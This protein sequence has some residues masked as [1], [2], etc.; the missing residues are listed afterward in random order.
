MC[1]KDLENKNNTNLEKKKNKGYIRNKSN[2]DQKNP[3]NINEMR[4]W[5]LKRQIK[6]TSLYPGQPRKQINKNQRLKL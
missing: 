2:K 5:F 3:H 4:S 6:L 1:L